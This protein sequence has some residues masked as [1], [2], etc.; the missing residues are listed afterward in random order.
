M[1]NKNPPI[2]VSQDEMQELHRDMRSA[3]IHAWVNKN[4]Q[5][6][7]TG[8]I[9]LIIVIVG[10][11][12]YKERLAKQQEGAATLFH[13]AM[14]TA[15]LENKQLFFETVVKDYDSSSYAAMSL[16]ILSSVDKKNSKNHLMQLLA[17]SKCSL[18]MT[19]Q[20]HLDLASIY[21][22]E[23]DIEKAKAELKHQVGKE[24]A[25]LRYYLLAQAEKNPKA[26]KDFLKKAQQAVSHDKALQKDIEQQLSQFSSAT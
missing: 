2:E 16:M 4:Q 26:K 8:L 23:N 11:G 10:A 3:R 17:H 19:W 13:Q 9:L 12:M 7:F 14:D 25:E 15:N 5:H 22:N 6:L 18:E 21:I 24:Y 20:A 1:D